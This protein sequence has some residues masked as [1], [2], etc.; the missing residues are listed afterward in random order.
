MNSGNP[1]NP[2][3]ASRRSLRRWLV[4]SVPILL[5]LALV[6]WWPHGGSDEAMLLLGPKFRVI[7]TGEQTV[8]FERADEG[9]VVH[10]EQICDAFKVGEEYALLYRQKYLE[11]RKWGKKYRL[12][13]VEYRF[14]PNTVEGGKG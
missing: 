4:W 6:L 2:T 10:C 9:F 1:A 11:Y 5:V 3:I 13:I 12:P 14:H 7:S 8:T